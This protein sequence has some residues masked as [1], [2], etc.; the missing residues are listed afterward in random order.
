MTDKKQPSTSFY[1]LPYGDIP[2]ETRAKI[3]A[4]LQRVGGDATNARI[5]GVTGLMTRFKTPAYADGGAKILY[6][7]AQQAAAWGEAIWAHEAGHIILGHTEKII[8]NYLNQGNYAALKGLERDADQSAVEAGYGFALADKF[9]E[10][11]SKGLGHKPQHPR[12]TT[13]IHDVTE[14]A[15]KHNLPHAHPKPP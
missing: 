13:R 8:G 3:K 2:E 1:G 4:V 15:V 12:L 6:V 7:D 11:R 5:V 10:A 9:K 14:A